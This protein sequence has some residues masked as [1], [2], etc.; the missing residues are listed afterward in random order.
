MKVDSAIGTL[1][2]EYEV[3]GPATAVRT[4]HLDE[5]ART[6]LVAVLEHALTAIYGNDPTVYVL[7][8]VRAELALRADHAKAACTWGQALATAIIETIET[9]PGDGA[10]LVRFADEAEYVARYLVD[11]L[12]GQ[13]DHWY[14]RPLAGLRDLP[15]AEAVLTLLGDQP[16]VPVLAALH[17]HGTLQEVLAVLPFPARAEVAELAVG[18]FDTPA[19]DLAGLW[20]LI[21][22][23]VHLADDWPLWTGSP[24]AAV[25]VARDYRS[26]PTPDWRNPAALTTIVVEILRHLESRGEIRVPDGEPPAAVLAGVDWLDLPLLRRA[27]GVRAPL[28]RQARTPLEQHISRALGDLIGRM[29]PLGDLPTATIRLRAALAAEHPEWVAEPAADVVVARVVA[30]LLDIDAVDS[31]LPGTE[32]DVVA[33]PGVLADGVEE[34]EHAGVLLLLRA[35]SDFRL[36]AVLARSGLSGWLPATL[37]AV[38]MRLT[39]ADPRDPAVRAFAGASEDPLDELA[40]W[41]GAGVEDCAR[42]AEELD[43][44]LVRHGLE[45]TGLADLTDGRLGVTPVDDL[46]GRV[47]VAVL[48]AWSRWLNQFA[49]SSIPYLLTHFVRRPGRLR[50][51]PDRLTV[52]LAPRLLDVVVQLAGYDQDL[53]SVPWLGGKR[54]VFR[55]DGS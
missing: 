29:A 39:G 6:D 36:P 20:P 25:D 8:E 3:T 13:A 12:H 22:A 2:C 54:V 53:E 40:V 16:T 11:F 17:R 34:S 45:L 37:L 48:R 52:E 30:R 44:M 50:W 4:G 27:L 14:Y 42:V 43:T 24:R 1:R 35:V 7:R 21:L 15:T 26:R 33:L 9:D 32:E 5:V 38:A 41:R 28:T 10:N 18:R 49:E 46:L 55:M 51:A 23:A 47:A 31:G 19:D